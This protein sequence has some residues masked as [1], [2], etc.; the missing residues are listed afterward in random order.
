MT[1]AQPADGSYH[2]GELTF[3]TWLDDDPAGRCTASHTVDGPDGPVTVRCD[4]QAGHGGDRHQG[5]LA[6]RPV[7]WTGD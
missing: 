5:S 6:G 3:P 2:G 1:D 4:G 7:G